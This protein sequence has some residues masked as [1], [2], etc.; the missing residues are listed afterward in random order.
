MIKQII[1]LITFLFGCSAEFEMGS[2]IEINGIYKCTS[3]VVG[4]PIYIFDTTADT[5]SVEL[6]TNGTKIHFIDIESGNKIVLTDDSMQYAC[7]IIG[8]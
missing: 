5:S 7:E 3:P 6:G 4:S 2:S 1:I 8:T